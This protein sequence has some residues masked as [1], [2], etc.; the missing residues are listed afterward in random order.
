M[1]SVPQKPGRVLITS[2]CIYCSNRV[3]PS[4]YLC[5]S[6]TTAPNK[7]CLTKQNKNTSWF[8]FLFL[9]ENSTS[10]QHLPS[11]G[12]NI[13]LEGLENL[14]TMLLKAEQSPA[15]PSLVSLFDHKLLTTTN[16]CSEIRE[17]SFVKFLNHYAVNIAQN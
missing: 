16:S 6:R 9:P 7:L 1:D 13:C 12:E 5:A 10:S 17:K 4:S 11:I 15:I 3:V 14:N 2:R 8:F